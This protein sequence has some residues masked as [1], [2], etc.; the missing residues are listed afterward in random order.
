MIKKI[1]THPLMRGRD[2]DD[3]ET[4]QIRKTLIRQKQYLEKIYQEWYALISERLGKISSPVLE[5]GA[6]AGFLEEYIP[7]LI[8]TEIFHLNGMDVIVDGTRIPFKNE[9]LQAI[10][11]TDVFHHIPRPAEFLTE[12]KRVLQ[13]NG[14]VVMI[15]P[16]VSRWSRWVYPRFHHEPFQPDVA[17]WDFPTSGPLS[18]SNQALPWIVFERDQAQFLAHFPEFSIDCIK[19]MMPFRYLISGGVSMRSLAPKWSFGFWKWLESLIEKQMMYL[20][21]F[22]YIEILK[23]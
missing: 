18:S 5:L 20:G 11:M 1:L 19:P 16:W 2:L 4:T 10:V 12:A 17:D 3:P 6:G 21:M 22:A 23:S 15:E 14:R 9:S 13:K 8:K 7:T